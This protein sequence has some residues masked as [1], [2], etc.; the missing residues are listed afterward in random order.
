MAAER[1]R[2]LREK[3][4]MF[5]EFVVPVTAIQ[6]QEAARRHRD[7]FQTTLD[8][9]KVRGDEFRAR[10]LAMAS[11]EI[12]DSL[13]EQRSKLPDGPEFHADFWRQALTEFQDDD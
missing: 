7:R 8:S 4:G 5:A 3:E 13:D 6:I 2:K 12:M 10:V 11:R 9:L 1:T